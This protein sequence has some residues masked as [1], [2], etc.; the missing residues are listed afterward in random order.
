MTVESQTKLPLS[1]PEYQSLEQIKRGRT[2]LTVDA[3]FMLSSLRDD[4]RAFLKINRL[5]RPS[6]C[7]SVWILETVK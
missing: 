4:P 1:A 2:W 6:L 5:S 7:G 3:N